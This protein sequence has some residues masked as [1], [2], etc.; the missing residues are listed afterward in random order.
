[1]GSEP[2]TKVQVTV[3]D[4]YVDGYGSTWLN[5]DDALGRENQLFSQADIK[6]WC[7]INIFKMCWQNTDLYYYELNLLWKWISTAELL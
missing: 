3:V 1:M 5:M 6:Y 2:G 7:K 4:G